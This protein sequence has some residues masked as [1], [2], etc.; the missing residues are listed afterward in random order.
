MIVEEQ[1]V[2]YSKN[3]FNCAKCPRKGGEGGCPAWWETHHT[4]TLTG[5]L[6]IIKSC[7]FEQ[8]PVYLIEVIK[9]ASTTVGTTDAL[10]NEIG[11]GLRGI[12]SLI[13]VTKREVLSIEAQPVDD[14]KHSE[15]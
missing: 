9:A 13:G 10:R 12:A 3:A 5:E 6:K 2:R 1:K 8:L 15:C 14:G 4:N 11:G 7:G